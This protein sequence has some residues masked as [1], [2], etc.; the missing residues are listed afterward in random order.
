LF[1]VVCCVVLRWEDHF[2]ISIVGDFDPPKS[3]SF[4][5]DKKWDNKKGRWEE[6]F[7]AT[8]PQA[9]TMEEE[10]SSEYSEEEVEEEY[11]IKY[12]IEEARLPGVEKES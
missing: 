11:E 6:H 12:V 4:G 8:S 9:E 2:A 3:K 7:V 10:F 1:V 5:D